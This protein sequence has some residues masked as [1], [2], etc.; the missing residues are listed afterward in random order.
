MGVYVIMT[1]I[2]MTGLFMAVLHMGIE[3]LSLGERVAAMEAELKR[4]D[5]PEGV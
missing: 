1:V 2:L 5:N 3:I 4:L